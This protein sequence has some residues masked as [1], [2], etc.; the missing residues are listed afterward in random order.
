MTIIGIWI[1]NTAKSS[2]DFGFIFLGQFIASVGAPF[3]INAPQ[4]V[5]ATWHKIEEGPF[6]TAIHSVMGPLG[7][8]LGMGLTQFFVENNPNQEDGLLQ[9]NSMNRFYTVLGTVC[10]IPHFFLFKDKPDV[11]PR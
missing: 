6:Y 2:S 9:V 7:I 11:P 5:S 10:L 8:G 4:K 3:I 1:R